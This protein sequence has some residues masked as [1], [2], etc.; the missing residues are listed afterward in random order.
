MASNDS[1]IPDSRGRFGDW[2][3]VYNDEDTVV[4]MAGLHLTD[5]LANPTRWQFPEGITIPAKGFLLVWADDDGLQGPLHTNF[6][7]ARGGEDIGLFDSEQN[8]HQPIHTVT[9]GPQMVD[10]SSGLLPDGAGDVLFLEEA[11]PGR[12]N[13][14]G[15]SN[16]GWILY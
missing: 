12:S 7:L 3:E 11:T 13:V 4:D 8:N 6:N 2:L 10:V 15:Q 16:A 5:D 14:L 1:T 9:Y